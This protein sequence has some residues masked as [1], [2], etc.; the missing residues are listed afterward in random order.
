MALLGLVL[1][2]RVRLLPGP[3]KYI[4]LYDDFLVIN[5][6]KKIPELRSNNVIISLIYG[7]S[8]WCWKCTCGSTIEALVGVF[9]CEKCAKKVVN[10]RPSY[11]LRVQDGGEGFYKVT[12]VCEDIDVMREFVRKDKL[13]ILYQ[14]H[15]GYLFAPLLSRPEPS[16]EVRNPASVPAFSVIRLR[17]FVP[18]GEGASRSSMGLNCGAGLA[19]GNGNN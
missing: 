6:A 8:W 17:V 18:L 3:K 14:V 15:G 10:V 12:R 9:N 1:E 13:L 2:G 16:E 4:S 19:V 7:E 5:P 11:K